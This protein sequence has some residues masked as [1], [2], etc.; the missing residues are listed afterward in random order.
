MN[1]K[2]R[3]FF[4]NYPCDLN[5]VTRAY[6][7][8]EFTLAGNRRDEAEVKVRYTQN[9]RSTIPLLALKMEEVGHEVRSVGG[10]SK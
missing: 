5:R 10:L 9:V 7:C 2:I 4:L 1:F 6:K 8:R 3:K